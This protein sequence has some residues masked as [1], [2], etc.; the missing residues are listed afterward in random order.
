[1][2]D[3]RVNSSV[4]LHYPRPQVFE[5]FSLAE[6][7][8]LLTPPWLRFSILTPLPIDT[9]AGARFAYRIRL[10]GLPVRWES[11]ITEWEPPCRFTD[12]QIRGPYRRWVHRHRFEETPG[13]TLV[14]DEVTYQVLGGALANR[15]FVAGEVRKIFDYRKARLLELFP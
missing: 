4:L 15:L 12:T 2:P 8:D 14:T 13:G 10:H 11:E 1:M 6:N 5:F 3:F 9:K 7:L